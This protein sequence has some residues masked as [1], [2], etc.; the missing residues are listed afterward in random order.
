MTIK[1]Q[2]VL[3]VEDSVLL[4]KM[5]DLILMRYRDRGATVVHA[6]NGKEALVQLNDHPD[7]DLIILDINMPVMSGLEF[8]NYRG[9]TKVFQGIPVIL[10]TTEGREEDTRRGLSA[11]ARAYLS[12]PFHP[13]DLHKLIDKIFQGSPH[14][15]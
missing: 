15:N 2:K 13:N 11:G 6:F 4:H 5:Y 12:K 7:T 9:Q 10:V 3:V 1:L 8:L 14:A